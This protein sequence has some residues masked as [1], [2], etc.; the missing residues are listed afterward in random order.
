MGIIYQETRRN[1]MQEINGK[2][3]YEAEDIVVGEIYKRGREAFLVKKISFDKWKIKNY[4]EDKEET[5][6]NVVEG[7]R[8]HALKLS[9]ED[10][11]I[12]VLRPGQ[13]DYQYNQDKFNRIIEMT[14]DEME[15][16][17]EGDLVGKGWDV[18]FNEQKTISISLE[19]TDKGSLFQL[20]DWEG[21][22][23]VLAKKKVR[24]LTFG[25]KYS[26]KDKE[27]KTYSVIIQ[28]I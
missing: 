20:I 18:Y 27:G 22:E 8:V 2:L 23:Q 15:E 9:N 1:K 19:I 24:E 4:G 26:L 21:N 13:F 3:Y 17:H 7:W 16:I 6:W 11:R 14:N 10:K 5:P 28:E 12:S 25:K